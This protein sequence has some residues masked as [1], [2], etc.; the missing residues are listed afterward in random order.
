MFGQQKKTVEIDFSASY[1][2]NKVVKAIKDLIMSAFT[3]ISVLVIL[4]I[5]SGGHGDSAVVL[6]KDLVGTAYF[7]WFGQCLSYEKYA[8]RC[9]CPSYGVCRGL[10]CC[11]LNIDRIIIPPVIRDPIFPIPPIPDPI[12]RRG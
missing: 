1:Q 7:P 3:S 2:N 6:N 9:P 8:G 5:I 12:L 11:V 10:K 4:V